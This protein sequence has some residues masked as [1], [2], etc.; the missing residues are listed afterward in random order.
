MLLICRDV[1]EHSTLEPAILGPIFENKNTTRPGK[2]L[3]PIT[4]ITL[5]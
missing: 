2:R 3:A 4:M 1:D 5:V